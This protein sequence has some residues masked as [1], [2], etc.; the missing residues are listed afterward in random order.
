MLAIGDLNPAIIDP[1][2]A[3][4]NFL[5][6]ITL[7]YPTALSFAAGRPFDGLLDVE[8]SLRF[9][10]SYV[11]H[12]S[13]AADKKTVE[14]MNGL[15]QYG[16]T[17]GLIHELIAEML[18]N[19]E[20]MEVDPD[21]IVVTAGA[22]EAMALCVA[23]LCSKTQDVALAS[24]PGY[25]GF[26]GIAKLLGTTLEGIVVDGRSMNSKLIRNRL[27]RLSDQGRR[28]RLLYCNPDFS[29][30]SG[31]QMK[32][33]A[34]QELLRISEEYDLLILED[35]TYRY[36]SFD[37]TELPSLK[38]L[39]ENSR[40]IYCGTFSKTLFPGLRVGYLVADQAIPVGDGSYPL[41]DDLSKAKSMFTN[42]T[43]PIC[44]AIVGGY[45]LEHGRSLRAAVQPKIDFYRKNRDVLLA[46]FNRYFPRNEY[47]VDGVEWSAPNGGF[48]ATLRVPFEIDHDALNESAS[49]YGVI[50]VPM[51]DFY[52]GEGGEY[53]IRLAFSSLGPEQIAEG[54]RRL[55]MF[56]RSRTARDNEASMV[57]A[58]SRA[59]SGA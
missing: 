47:W 33:A 4:M 54:I 42:N 32:L 26:A 38:A 35:S 49:E 27:A 59:G 11:D 3:S 50:W 22:Q 57:G 56:V 10:R 14:L 34:R 40:V 18:G 19:D 23:V 16:R 17:K 5:N 30:P 29:N 28:A 8:D 37:Q 48:F 39:D 7:Q 25:V 15:G 12:E 53:E 24:E 55:G 44:Q 2:L 36:F 52:L 31:H 45:L 1:V 21:V 9:V 13:V 20:G 43:S 58:Q 46:S 41:A 51:R 6:E